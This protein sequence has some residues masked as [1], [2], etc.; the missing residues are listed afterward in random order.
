MSKSALGFGR[1]VISRTPHQSTSADAATRAGRARPSRAD[2]VVCRPEPEHLGSRSD[3]A[4][5]AVPI[6]DTKPLDV[7][8]GRKLGRFDNL[9]VPAYADGV[10]DVFQRC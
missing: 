5:V 4:T 6:A 3:R 9:K 2:P 7:H 1:S 10:H 8:V